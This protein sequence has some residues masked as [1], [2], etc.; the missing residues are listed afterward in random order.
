MV[1][2][3]FILADLAGKSN[4]TC[5]GLPSACALFAARSYA[6][7]VPVGRTTGRRL[8]WLGSEPLGSRQFTDEREA[9]GHEFG[10]RAAVAR[11][12]GVDDLQMKLSVP[13][14]AFAR[15]A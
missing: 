5:E 7:R 15:R 10:R 9:P 4:P 11:D 1:L 12:D 13:Q 14:A 8:P 3:G 6:H 2:H